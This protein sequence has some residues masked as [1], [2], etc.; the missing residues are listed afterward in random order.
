MSVPEF[1]A[2]YPEFDSA[3]VELIVAKIQE[4]ARWVDPG[5]WGDQAPDGIAT[6]AAH[7][8]ATSPFGRNARLAEDNDRSTYGDR[9]QEL[10]RVAAIGLRP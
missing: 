9:F 7:L 3:G 6:L 4:A 1:L 8:L 2:R 10:K 5:V